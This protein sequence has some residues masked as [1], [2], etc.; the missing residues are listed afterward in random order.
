MLSFAKEGGTVGRDEKQSI[1][2]RQK[3]RGNRVPGAVF[4]RLSLAWVM[5]VRLGCARG[6]ARP[7]RDGL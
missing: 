5:S 4:G 7:L 6:G 2:V 3:E 1:L